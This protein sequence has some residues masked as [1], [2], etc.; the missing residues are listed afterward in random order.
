MPTLEGEGERMTQAHEDLV[1]RPSG[2]LI[3]IIETRFQTDEAIEDLAKIGIGAD[4]VLTYIGPQGAEQLQGGEEGSGGFMQ[5]LGRLISGAAMAAEDAERYEQAARAGQ[6]VL[7]VHVP[8]ED[9]RERVL[10]LMRVH[11][12]RDVRYC[13]GSQVE[14]YE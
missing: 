10:D 2:Y 4:R 1:V 12:G 13:A 14:R 7:A 8:E 11:G 9:E 3:A 6:C 5:A